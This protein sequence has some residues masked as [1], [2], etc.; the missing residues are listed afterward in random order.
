MICDRCDQPVEGEPEVIP[1]DSASGA[2]PDVYLCPVPCRP[3]MPRQTAPA[4]QR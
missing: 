3:A 4:G 2:V 1:V